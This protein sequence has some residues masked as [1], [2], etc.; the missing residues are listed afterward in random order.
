[1]PFEGG[2]AVFDRMFKM[3]RRAFPHIKCEQLSVLLLQNLRR[4][5]ELYETQQLMQ[6]LLDRGDESA[7]ELNS[8]IRIFGCL[9]Q[10]RKAPDTQR[11]E[12]L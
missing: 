10:N 9:S 7:Q 5:P 12:T 6:D 2:I 4:N 11:V 8:W 3:R 1:M